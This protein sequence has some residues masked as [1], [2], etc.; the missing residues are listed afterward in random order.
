MQVK[1]LK[2]GDEYDEGSRQVVAQVGHMV[3]CDDSYGVRRGRHRAAYTGMGIGFGFRHTLLGK[4]L[5]KGI[6]YK[7]VVEAYK[8]NQRIAR[9]NMVHVVTKGGR[10]TNPAKLYVNLTKKKARRGSYLRHIS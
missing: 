2:E 10:Y 8:G 1:V 5:K 6:Y 9:S 4:K 3:D 7:F